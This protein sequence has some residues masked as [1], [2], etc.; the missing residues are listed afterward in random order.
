MKP[1]SRALWA[2]VPF[3]ALPALVAGVLAG[4]LGGPVAGVVAAVV[5]GCALALWAR[6]AG[7]KLVAARLQGREADPRSDA[8]LCNL[9]EGLSIT[10]GLRQPR[11]IVVDSPGMNAMV[12]G[13]RPRNAVLAVTS[14][15]LR[16]LDRI[17]LEAVL[18]EELVQIRHN[19][20]F[21]AT[22]LVAT[23]G[24]GRS[25]VVRADHDLWA[26]GGAVKLTRY[27]PAL[28]SALE[29]VESGGSEVTG[30]PRYMSHLWLAPP[31]ATSGAQTGRLPVRERI[32]ALRE[33]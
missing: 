30:V 16:G 31:G 19:E 29:K 33:L 21:A 11:T 9:V 2:A 5:I 28:A 3:A 13:T 18:A 14:G 22:V 17:E 25:K 12:G 23:F 8:R 15:L 24:V 20:T 7:D 10:A 1:A 27:P 26:D 32:E 6:F 4:L